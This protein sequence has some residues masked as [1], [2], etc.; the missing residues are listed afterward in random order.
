M[1][2]TRKTKIGMWIVVLNVLGYTA[3]E[4]NGAYD[5]LTPD[6]GDVHANFHAVSGL[7]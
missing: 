2:L 3:I 5:Q 6:D 4:I 1:Q 7:L